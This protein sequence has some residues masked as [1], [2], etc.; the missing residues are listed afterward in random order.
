MKNYLSKRIAERLVRKSEYKDRYEIIGIEIKYQRIKQNLTQEALAKDICSL[1]YLCKIETS[2]IEA[3]DL[4][5]REICKRLDISGDKIEALLDSRNIL[6]KT[7]AAY[8]IRDIDK[9]DES[10]ELVSSFSNYRCQ[11]IGLIHSIS[12]LDIFSANKYHDVLLSLTSNMREFDFIIYSLFSAILQYYNFR[13]KEAYDVLIT[14]DKFDLSNELYLLKNIYLFLVSYAQNKPE[15]PIYYMNLRLD[16]VDKGLIKQYDEMRYVICLFYIKNKAYP[17]LDNE[18]NSLINPYYKNSILVLKDFFDNNI[19]RILKSDENM[20]LMANYIKL[21][22][23]DKLQLKQRL[24]E[25]DY[26]YYIYD[27]DLLY[28]LSL[29]HKDEDDYYSFLTD[30][31]LPKAGYTDDEY[32]K[33]Y[34]LKEIFRIS[35]NLPNGIRNK[36]LQKSYYTLYGV[37][38]YG[39]FNDMIKKFMG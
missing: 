38:D 15:T 19:S 39:D 6:E 22:V 29:V 26:K 25:I 17:L 8:L 36:N 24:D 4:F 9:I 21:Y 31:L 34:L 3:N 37:D 2:Q 28:L 11:I 27:F 5:L 1:S 33:A 35:E 7:V 18:I 32:I 14:L 13:F 10:Y 16:L 20:S 12:H 23:I 30:V